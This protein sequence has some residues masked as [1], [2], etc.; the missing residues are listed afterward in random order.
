[1]TPQPRPHV[2]AIAKEAM[3][4]LAMR[5]TGAATGFI[6]GVLIAR[7][8]GPSEFGQYSLVV[9]WAALLA[10]VASIGWPQLAPREFAT[11]GATGRTAVLGSSRGALWHTFSGAACWPERP[12]RSLLSQ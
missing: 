6:A 3:A 2:A 7:A 12:S 4:G 1:M 11:L 8:L 5:L 10:S 9:A